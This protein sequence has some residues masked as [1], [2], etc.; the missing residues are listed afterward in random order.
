MQRRRLDLT[1]GDVRDE[2]CA[3]RRAIERDEPGR[4]ALERLIGNGAALLVRRQIAALGLDQLVDG[5]R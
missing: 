3:D 1:A 4:V 5:L 2:R